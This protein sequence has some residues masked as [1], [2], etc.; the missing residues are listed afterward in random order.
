MK[1]FLSVCVWS[2]IVLLSTTGA[3]VYAQGLWEQNHS[4]VRAF[5]YS[6]KN[7]K[8]S[9]GEVAEKNQW[10]ISENQKFKNNI[11][12]LQEEIRS[13]DQIHKKIT[14]GSMLDEDEIVEELSMKNHG[15]NRLYKEFLDLDEEQ[16]T[17][18]QKLA[19]KRRYKREVM[20]SLNRLREEIAQL[21]NQIKTLEEE[22]QKREINRVHARL[23]ESFKESEEKLKV[24][25][26]KYDQLSKKLGKPLKVFLFLKKENTELRQKVVLLEDELKIFQEEG[27]NIGSE[28]ER[29]KK[30]NSNKTSLINQKIQ[31]LKYRKEELEKVLSMVNQKFD[32]DFMVSDNGIQ[33]ESVTD[34]LSF[35]KG[36]NTALSNQIKSL[37]KLIREKK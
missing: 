33:L 32:A 12:L 35:I 30:L 21:E 19:V 5:E 7:L 11:R 22:S 18:E 29:I 17:L 15:M 9:A 14:S 37:E 27:K 24:A 26:K 1:K 31:F 4:S 10:L 28:I 13:L 25:S 20:D 34:N 3:A 8:D 36:E 16:K 23:L 6:L 2:L